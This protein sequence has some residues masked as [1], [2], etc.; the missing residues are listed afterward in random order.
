MATG[1]KLPP[2]IETAVRAMGFIQTVK[3]KDNGPGMYKHT[4]NG[5]QYLID[6]NNGEICRLEVTERITDDDNDFNLAAL[7]QRVN[8]LIAD[9]KKSPKKQPAKQPAP[10][11]KSEQ[12]AQPGP[13]SNATVRCSS[14][15]QMYSDADTVPVNDEIV[16]CR[17]CWANPKRK[18]AEPVVPPAPTKK[19]EQEQQ[20]EEPEPEPEEPAEVPIEEPPEAWPNVPPAYESTDAIPGFRRGKRIRGLVPKLCEVGKIKIGFKGSTERGRPPAKTNHFIITTLRKTDDDNFE[21]DAVMMERIGPDCTELPITFLYDDPDVN[22]YTCYAWYGSSVRKCYGDGETATLADGTEKK[23]DPE[24]CPMYLEKKC[25]PNGIL[26]VVLRDSPRVGGVHKFRTTGWNSIINIT[27]AL[28]FIYG[29]TGGILAGLD[30]VMT[31][32]PKAVNVTGLAGKQV[33][34]M[35]NIEFRGSLEQLRAVAERRRGY[36]LPE[37]IIEREVQAR[38]MMETPETPEECK[39]VEEEFYQG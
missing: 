11:K 35:V 22:F 24:T 19:P 10:P 26:S 5:K 6:F 21:Q 37:R 8:E 28:D 38:T 39:D 9:V 1:K 2:E 34:Y 18:P 14:C 20:T 30:L 16:L 27:S 4:I 29:L 31:L 13:A 3:G 7:K 17:D 32:Q 23:C 12:P 15:G 25:K 33:I 36:M